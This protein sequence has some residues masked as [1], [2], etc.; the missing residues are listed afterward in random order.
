AM[1]HARFL[2]ENGTTVIDLA[3]DFRLQSLQDF[4]PWYKLE[5]TCPDILKDAV[6]WLPEVNRNAIAKAKVIGNPGCYPTTEQRH[7]SL[8]RQ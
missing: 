2:T 6:Y 8:P 4:E 7:R 5:H 1:K 3:A